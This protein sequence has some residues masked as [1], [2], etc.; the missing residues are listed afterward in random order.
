MAREVPAFVTHYHLA[1]K[2]P[3]LNLSDLAEAELAAVMQDL[4]QRRAL[5][6]LKRVFGPRY[7]RLR[8]LTEDRLHELFLQAGGLP[9]RKAPHY[10]VLGSSEWYRG[11]APDTREVV[12]RL[13]DLPSEVMSF[14]YPDSFTAMAFG[15]QFGI[16]LQA[17]PYHKQ[18]FRLEQLKDVVAQYGLP[19]DATEDGYEG[20]AYRPFEKYIEVQVWSDEPIRPF[21]NS[22]RSALSA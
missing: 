13:E 22:R 8:R 18:V 6:G 19:A 4:E 20:Y 5:S 3:F 11:L 14:T 21:L 17:R 2:Q 16:P 10:F 7:M 12:L 1:D 9:K 15:P